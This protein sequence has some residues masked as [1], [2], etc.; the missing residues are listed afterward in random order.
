M[1]D[2]PPRPA[3]TPRPH[4]DSG[5]L[6]ILFMRF[7]AAN[8]LTIAG[9][10]CLLER[11]FLVAAPIAVAATFTQRATLVLYRKMRDR[12]AVA[13]HEMQGGAPGVEAQHAG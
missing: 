3:A 11:R 2:F 4:V 6:L 1:T 8:F 12:Y 9:L 10:F 7:V 13:L 5:D